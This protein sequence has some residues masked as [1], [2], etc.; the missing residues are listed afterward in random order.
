MLYFNSKHL[1]IFLINLY[2]LS[3]EIMAGNIAEVI[4]LFTGGS[5]ISVG[6]Q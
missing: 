2:D 3:E 5:K 6:E 1:N 4:N